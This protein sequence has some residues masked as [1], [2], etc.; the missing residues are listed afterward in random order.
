MNIHCILLLMM[1]VFREKNQFK[2]RLLPKI[3]DHTVVGEIIDLIL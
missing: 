3:I 1:S 2:I